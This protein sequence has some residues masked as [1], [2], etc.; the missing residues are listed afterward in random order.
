[1][2]TY[3]ETNMFMGLEW[4]V[5]PHAAMEMASDVITMPCLGQSPALTLAGFEN[6]AWDVG[7]IRS[8]VFAAGLIVATVTDLRHGKI[9]N[10]LTVPLMVFALAI[11]T[12]TEFTAKAG[13]PDEQPVGGLNQAITGGLVCFGL[14]YLF[15][16]TAGGGGGDV[17]LVTAVG[18]GFGAAAGLHVIAL[19][20]GLA[21]AGDT[22]RRKIR[23]VADWL[24]N[25][26]NEELSMGRHMR[27]EIRMAPWFL[28]AILPVL[29][30]IFV[31]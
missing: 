16:V 17:K 4:N 3:L 27:R 12:I 21:W 29:T 19:A 24:K 10:W 26:R 14:M 9:H 28:L 22:A 15:Y 1:M 25:G 8:V 7:N 6:G 31:P 11:A 2:S 20:Y 13:L 30:G 23:I 18:F 5:A